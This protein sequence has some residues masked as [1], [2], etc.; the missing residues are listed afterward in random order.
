MQ[1]K[2]PKMASAAGYSGNRENTPAATTAPNLQRESAY[3]ITT[4]YQGT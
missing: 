3:I 2:N 1:K 4:P